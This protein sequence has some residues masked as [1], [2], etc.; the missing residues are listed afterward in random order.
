M[1]NKLGEVS[2]HE[3]FR[4]C[5]PCPAVASLYRSSELMNSY[6]LVFTKIGGR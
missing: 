3:P 5:G 6:E 1:V 4:V 2:V